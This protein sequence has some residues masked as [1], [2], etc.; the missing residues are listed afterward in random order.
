MKH[1]FHKAAVNF[2]FKRQECL[3]L[4]VEL[5]KW[6]IVPFSKDRRNLTNTIKFS[7][8]QKRLYYVHTR[9]TNMLDNVM[10]KKL[11]EGL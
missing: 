10:M 7:Y 11:S 6:G 2:D 4:L 8:N 1:N 3:D 5:K 9:L